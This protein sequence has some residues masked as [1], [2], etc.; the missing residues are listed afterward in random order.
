MREITRRGFLKLTGFC[1]LILT[2][3]P[4]KLFASST[5]F[6][7]QELPYPSTALEPHI[8]KMTMEIHHGKHHFG[9]VTN[10]NRE[11]DKDN[12]LSGSTLEQINRSVSKYSNAV[13]NNAGGHYNHSLFWKL[14]ATAGKGGSPS[15]ELDKA[16]TNS[17]GSL[18]AMKDE[19]K[20]TAL[21]QFG[22]GWAWLIFDDK[23][24]LKICSTPNQDNPIM[25]IST[26]K[27]EPILAIDVWEHAYYLK[28]QNR[29]A[30][31]ID[32]IWNIINWNEVNKL[33]TKAKDS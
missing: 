8:D 22:S 31:Y 19:L 15:K 16:I 30:D 7:L 21:N 18:E 26:V 9:Y 24:Q 27:G 14:L 25:D 3:N 12:T 29:R 10:L 20:N 5:Q 17:F 23:K 1:S 32:N 11:I 2:A 6:Q 33:F 28:Y 13:R 4:L